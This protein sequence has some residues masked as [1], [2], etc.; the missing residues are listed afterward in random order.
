MDLHGADP[1]SDLKSQLSSQKRKAG[2]GQFLGAVFYP[3]S[4]FS[5]YAAT[6]GGVIWQC[7]VSGVADTLPKRY[8]NR[9]CEGHEDFSSCKAVLEAIKFEG[10]P[11]YVKMDFYFLSCRYINCNAV[12][13]QSLDPRCACVG[14]V[15]RQV[16]S[17]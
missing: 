6:K 12:Q 10:K 4:Q 9:I 5:V 3:C 8:A 11:S 15:I 17:R 1:W 14:G 13:E 16:L 7:C 2:C